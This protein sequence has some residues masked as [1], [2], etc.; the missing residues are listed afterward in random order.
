MCYNTLRGFNMFEK[1]KNLNDI[2]REN[3]LGIYKHWIYDSQTDYNNM[4]DFMEKIRYCIEDLNSEI[5]ILNNKFETKSIVYIICLTDWITEAYRCIKNLIKINIEDKEKIDAQVL[6]KQHKF[7]EAVRSFIVAHPSNTGKHP[8]FGFT[9]DLVCSDIRFQ[10]GILG[11]GR[12]TNYYYLDLEGIHT[13][14]N[15][16]NYD[17]YL[18]CYSLKEKLKYWHVIGLNI[19]DILYV[20]REYVNQLYELDIY[21]SKKKRY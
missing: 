7:L 13:T 17:I 20:A 14:E 2:R 9:G 5:E 18:K 15:L 19:K 16:L 3:N 6:I 1:I 8:D 12:Y 10:L 4:C 21:L 11:I